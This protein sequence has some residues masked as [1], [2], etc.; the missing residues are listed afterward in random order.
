MSTLSQKIFDTNERDVNALLKR[1]PNIK[2]YI[3][4]YSQIYMEYKQ[5]RLLDEY[6]NIEYT[7]NLEKIIPYLNKFNILHQPKIKMRQ[8]L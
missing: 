5:N 3:N 1:N 7:K 6:K 2:F 4:I 8:N